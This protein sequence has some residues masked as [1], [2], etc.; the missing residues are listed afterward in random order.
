MFR[1]ETEIAVELVGRL[2]GPI[3]RLWG[4]DRGLAEFLRRASAKL[5]VTVDELR[6]HDERE[7]AALVAR[8]QEYV[9]ELYAG[10]QLA[11]SWGHLDADTVSAA[12][13]LLDAE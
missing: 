9:S 13:L 7:Q 8:A 6:W 5:A 10:L 3:E 11:D 2:R 12:R 1:R 4:I